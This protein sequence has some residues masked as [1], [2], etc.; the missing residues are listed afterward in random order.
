MAGA[1]SEKFDTTR[2]M[3]F[4]FE[5]VQIVGT[6]EEAQEFPEPKCV[7]ATMPS[8]DSGAA[9]ALFLQWASNEQNC[10]LFTDASSCSEQSLA[11][12]LLQ[13]PTPSFLHVKVGKRIP[14][15]GAELQ[16][17]EER[18][19]LKKVEQRIAA[20]RQAEEAEVGKR[21]QDRGERGDGMDLDGGGGGAGGDGGNGGGGGAG[22][23]MIQSWPTFPMFA[24]VDEDIGLETSEYGVVRVIGG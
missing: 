20:Q 24:F 8:L 17:F 9:K 21:G 3:V 5:K 1:L 22:G 11:A 19:R 18:Q 16:A 4:D 14:L 10:I 15:Q 23:G 2:H 7:L 12:S 6:W 13:R